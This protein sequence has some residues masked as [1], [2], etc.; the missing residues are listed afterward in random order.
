MPTTPPGPDES[1][2]TDQP[3]TGDTPSGPN[4]YGQQPWGAAPSGQ[5]PADGGAPPSGAGPYGRQPWEQQGSEQAAYGQPTYGQAPY[6][7]GQHGQQPYG[8]ASGDDRTIAV[9]AH[10]S[11]VIAIIFSAGLL[12]F[13]GPLVVWLI[14]RDR[15]PL[16]R[17]AAASAFNFNITVWVAGVIGWICAV[18][19]ILLPVSIVLW[20]G[21]F[22]AQLVLSIKGAISANRGEVYRYPLQVPI[23][24]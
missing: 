14:W 3:A 2:G 16:I 13:L 19:L 1:P 12:S 4:G 18:T 11:P 23:L 8:P 9:L 5:P 22:V 7:A 20:V 21:A 24:R 10:L 17:N 6:G 15:G